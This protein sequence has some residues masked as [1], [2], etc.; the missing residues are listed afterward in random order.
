MLDII[1]GRATMAEAS[2]AYDLPPSEI[3]KWIEEGKKKGME[4]TSS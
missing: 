1:Q 3:E 2:R 4:C